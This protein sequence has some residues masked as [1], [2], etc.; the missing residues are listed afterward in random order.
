MNLFDV[1][2]NEK[3]NKKGKPKKYTNKHTL[4]RQKIIKLN[5]KKP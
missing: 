5:N 1:S 2:K 4:K 3:K